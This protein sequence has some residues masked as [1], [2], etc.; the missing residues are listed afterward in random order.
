MSDRYGA[1]KLLQL[2]MMQRL[3]GAV[4]ASAKGH[5]RVNSC[6][7]GLCQTALFRA[8]YFPVNLVTGLALQVVGRTS[9]VGSRTLMTAAFGG[10]ET[11][12]RFMSNC[13]LDRWP[14]LMKAEAGETLT[15]RVWNELMRLMEEIQPGVT[16]NI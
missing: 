6:N 12:G 9:E 10:E 5:V 8:M 11:H 2:M 4:D 13:E 15:G 3:A 16:D 7:P 14:E 1:T